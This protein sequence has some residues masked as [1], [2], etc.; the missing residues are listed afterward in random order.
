L[1]RGLP[2]DLTFSVLG[3]ASIWRDRELL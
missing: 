2:R 3:A 1:M